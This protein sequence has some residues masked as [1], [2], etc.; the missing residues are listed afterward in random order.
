MSFDYKGNL[1]RGYISA[2]AKELA[3]KLRYK[4]D[5]INYLCEALYCQKITETEDKYTNSAIALVGDNVLKLSLS[6]KFYVEKADKE[7]INNEKETYEK[8][9]TLKKICDKLYIPL[10]F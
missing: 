8:N 10:C 7:Y 9:E 3:E 5:N 1:N 2:K 6:H 4:F